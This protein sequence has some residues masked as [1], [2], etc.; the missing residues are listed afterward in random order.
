[1]LH[2]AQMPI[3]SRFG[4]GLAARSVAASVPAGAELRTVAGAE[5]VRV[6][7][8]TA[9]F[10]AHDTLV[11]QVRAEAGRGRSAHPGW[12]EE[13][14]LSRRER[15]F[16]NVDGALRRTERLRIAVAERD[17]R[18]VGYVLFR[19]DGT[20]EANVP[21][22]KTEVEE[23]VAVDP[24]AARAL[25]A[26]LVSLELNATV[27]IGHE[28]LDGW[29]FCLFPDWRRAAPSLGD[30]QWLRLIDLPAALAARRYSAPVDLVLEIDDPL[31]PANAGRW[32]LLG[33]R[34]RAEVTREAVAGA[35]IVGGIEALSAIYLG[36]TGVAI[37]EDAGL[38]RGVR[39]GALEELD[40]AFHSYRSP[41][42]PTP[43]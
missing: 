13:T 5:A 28:P 29:L 4:Y 7:F 37:L 12:T 20:W 3:Y 35:D 21:T 18:P 26:E 22:G 15:R 11:C 32:R 16:A 43:F 42:A 9:T 2:A 6:R 39:A 23:F 30:D 27:R 34:N 31:V 36:G 19:R 14:A 40:A 8:A 38:I 1:L 33:D 17:G 10:E 24:P 25:W 41:G